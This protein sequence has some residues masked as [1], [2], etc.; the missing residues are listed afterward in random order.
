MDYQLDSRKGDLSINADM[1]MRF[2]HLRIEEKFKD[3]RHAFRSIDKNFDRQLTFKEFMSG[4]GERRGKI[5]A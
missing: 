2:V 1:L 5:P 3:F 4:V